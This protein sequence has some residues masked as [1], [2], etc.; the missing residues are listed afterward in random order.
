MSETGHKAATF[1]LI[2]ERDWGYNGASAGK[3]ETGKMQMTPKW[4]E[5]VPAFVAMIENGDAKARAFAIGEITRA[6]RALDQFAE[7]EK[8]RERFELESG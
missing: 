6:M 5:M 2:A 1:R 4:E 8:V 7:R 3:T